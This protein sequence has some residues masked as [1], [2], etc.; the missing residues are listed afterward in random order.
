MEAF[1]CRPNA[2]SFFSSFIS[3]KTKSFLPLTCLSFKLREKANHRLHGC[4]KLETRLVKQ[5]GRELE[6]EMNSGGEEW[7]IELGKLRERCKE[8]RGMVELLECLEREAIM[9]EDEGRD[10]IDY[11]RRAR[12]FDKSSKVFQALKER[13]TP[14]Q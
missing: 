6:A 12:I 10:A 7:M 14:S 3:R 2:F 8:M 13:S 9:G 1:S 11:N 4:A 5:M